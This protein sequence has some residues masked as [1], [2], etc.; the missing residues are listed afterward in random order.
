MD[1]SLVGGNS[2]MAP[3]PGFG[4]PAQQPAYMPQPTNVQSLFQVYFNK[5]FIIINSFPLP[6]AIHTSDVQ[7][8]TIIYASG[9]SAATWS[10]SSDLST[11]KHFAKRRTPNDGIVLIRSSF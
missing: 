6:D 10:N 1:N 2:G 3:P 9:A 8:S 11:R 7:L 5:K 4:V